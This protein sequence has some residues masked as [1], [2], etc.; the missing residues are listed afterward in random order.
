MHLEITFHE[1]A[2][3]HSEEQSTTTFDKPDF[4]KFNMRFNNLDLIIIDAIA[5]R[6][7][8]SRSQI[9][10]SFIESMLKDFVLSCP[11]HEALVISEHAEKL[12]KDSTK[13]NQD[14]AWDEWYAH[15]TLRQ[16]HDYLWIAK[17]DLQHDIDHKNISK[18]FVTLVRKLRKSRDTSDEANPKP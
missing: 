1:K 2:F 17:N 18:E 9:I 7:D 13:S 11:S 15:T 16:D 12:S 10:N 5:K 6:N 14:F 8:T 3:A 4:K